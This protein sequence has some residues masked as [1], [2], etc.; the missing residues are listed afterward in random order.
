MAYS[1][2]TPLIIIVGLQKIASEIY[3]RGGIVSAVCHGGAIFPGIKGSDGKSIINGKKVT[4]F[5]TQGEK[6]EGILDVIESWNRPTIEK[7]AADAGGIYVAPPGPWDSFSV[8]DGNVVTGA[9]PASAE[10]TAEDAVAAFNRL[11]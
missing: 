4:G 3:S 8:T 1:H 5:T 9:N 11:N 10:K 6:E 7:S 2:G